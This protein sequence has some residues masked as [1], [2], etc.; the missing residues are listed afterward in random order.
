MEEQYGTG[1]WARPW[2]DRYE[3]LEIIGKG[4]MAVVYKA[5]DHR[6]GRNVAL[7]VLKDDYAL[8]H[9]YSAAASKRVP[10]RRHE[11]SHP[12]I[13]SVYDMG[14]SDQ[15]EYIVMDSSR[16]SISSNT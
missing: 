11:L 2:N 12:N 9:E 3:I 5:I 16:A 1:I 14:A 13:V 15:M 10:S 4:G 7:K 8:R 6:L